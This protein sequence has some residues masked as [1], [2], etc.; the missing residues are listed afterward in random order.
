MECHRRRVLATIA[1]TAANC[2]AGP[3]LLL[4]ADKVIE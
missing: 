3:P 2:L 1:C 4:R